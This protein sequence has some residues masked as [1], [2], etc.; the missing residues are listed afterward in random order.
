MDESLKRATEKR[1]A[2]N[3]ITD[4]CYKLDFEKFMVEIYNNCDPNMYGIYP[5]KKIQKD[6]EYTFLEISSDKNIG[7]A[8]INKTEFFEVKVSY[9]SKNK[10]SYNIKNI[11]KYQNIDYYLIILVDDNFK[12]NI[13]CVHK[14]VISDNPVIKLGFMSQTKEIN[15]QNDSPLYTTRIDSREIDWILG[16]RNILGGTKYSDLMSFIKNTHQKNEPQPQLK[17]REVVS[18]KKVGREVKTLVSFDVNGKIIRDVNNRET[19]VKLINYLGPSTLDGVV[20]ES[21]FK[22]YPYGEVSRPLNDGYY[23]NPK[24]SFRDIKKLIK[25]INLKTKYNVRIQTNQKHQGLHQME[26]SL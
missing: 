7:D 23:L 14:D 1:D 12:S 3:V 18:V 19:V 16:R 9:L 15:L 17:E 11:K 4:D 8:H 5:V 10:S 21:Q 26:L 13:Y 20:W 24:F 22:R 2:K 6:S 25:Q